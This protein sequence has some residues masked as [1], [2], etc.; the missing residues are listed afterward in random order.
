MR[1]LPV[2]ALLI[3]CT[4]PVLAEGVEEVRPPSDDALAD[5]AKPEMLHM[6]ALGNLVASSCSGLS[7]ESGDA[8]LI[9]AT[10][11]RLAELLQV[12]GN[13][14]HLAY[15]EPALLE[16]ALPDTCEKYGGE[17]RVLAQRLRAMGGATGFRP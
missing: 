11:Q 17:T 5:I 2:L 9:A 6:F 8:A 12:D 3:A 7:L 13:T 10:G 15:L 4:Q 16:M 1:L 14:Y